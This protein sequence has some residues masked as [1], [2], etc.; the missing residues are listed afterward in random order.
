MSGTLIYLAGLA[1]RHPAAVARLLVQVDVCLRSGADQALNHA[2][3]STSGAAHNALVLAIE[4]RINLILGPRLACAW[5][6][7]GDAPADLEWELAVAVGKDAEAHLASCEP[8]PAPLSGRYWWARQT[9]ASPEESIGPVLVCHVT[10][11]T[12][13]DVLIAHDAVAACVQK[14][15]GTPPLSLLYNMDVFNV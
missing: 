14:L 6:I 12:L 5:I 11:P 2:L 3:Q 4:H 1:P 15:V 7:P 13:P 9:L 10:A 8:P